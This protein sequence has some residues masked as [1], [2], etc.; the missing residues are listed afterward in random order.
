MLSSLIK[1]CALVKYCS[2]G[3]KSYTLWEEFTAGI[4]FVD[5]VKIETHD[6]DDFVWVTHIDEPTKHFP[7][8]S[9][10]RF[11]NS[12]QFTITFFFLYWVFVGFF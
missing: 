5:T 9:R 10:T 7:G 12:K 2:H 11:H 3:T 1:A 6:H 8:V 4:C